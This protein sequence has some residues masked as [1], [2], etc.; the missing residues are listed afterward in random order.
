MSPSIVSA[1]KSTHKGWRHSNFFAAF[2]GNI[3]TRG[4]N[5]LELEQNLVGIT[6]RHRKSRTVETHKP[7]ELSTKIY[8]ERRDF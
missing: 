7:T 8:D 2:K 5:S 1:R 3:G 6:Y 4:M